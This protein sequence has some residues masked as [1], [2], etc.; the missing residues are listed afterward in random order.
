MYSKEMSEQTQISA[1]ARLQKMVVRASIPHIFGRDAREGS[2]E[3]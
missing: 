3:V 1:E 2:T